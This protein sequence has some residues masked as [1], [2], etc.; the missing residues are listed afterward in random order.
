M[1]EMHPLL[2]ALGLPEY[3]GTEMPCAGMPL[4]HKCALPAAWQESK[5]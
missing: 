2:A 3:Q 1:H 4:M 5:A